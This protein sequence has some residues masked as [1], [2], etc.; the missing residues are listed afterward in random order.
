MRQRNS[1]QAVQPI[2]AAEPFPRIANLR[3]ATPELRR[4]SIEA[5]KHTSLVADISRSWQQVP[6]LIWEE[7]KAPVEVRPQRDDVSR[8]R[9]SVHRSS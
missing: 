6:K 1:V 9:E 7:E 5:D 4:P 8:W 3:F 2:S